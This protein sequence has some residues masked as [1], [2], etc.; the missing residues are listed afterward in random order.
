LLILIASFTDWEYNR[1]QGWG[2]QMEL[3]QLRYFIAVAERLSFSKAAQDLHITVPPLSRQIR[4]LEDEFGVPL[5]VRD[6]R[7]VALT[8]AGRTLLLEAK[9]LVAQTAHVSDC[10]RLAKRGESGL[11]SIGIGPGLGERVGRV[12]IDHAKHSPSVEFQ[13][14]DMC[15]GWQNKSLMDGDMDVGFLRPFVDT[16]RLASEVLFQEGFVVHMSRANPLAKRR[17]LRIRDLAGETLLLLNRDG[18]TGIYDKTLE[19]YAEAVVSPN[20]VHVP[21]D[22]TPR[23]D[24]QLVLLLCRKG[25]LILPDE[26][27]SRPVSGSE[28]AAVPLDEPNAKIDVYMAWRKNEKSPA[29]FAFIEAARRILR[30]PCSISARARIS[31]AGSAPSYSRELR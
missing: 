27:A 10:V 15:S 11:V 30:E 24:A 29:V 2:P 14:K 21:Q 13:C 18:C 16:A 4:Q 23:S 8:D 20:I 1:Q 6:R 5:F 19:L 3:R 25:I 12:L 22:A 17:S 31:S 26:A 7:H 9:S 28:T